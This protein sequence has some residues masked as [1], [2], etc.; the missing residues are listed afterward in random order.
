MRNRKDQRVTI[1]NG[2]LNKISVQ[3]G[4]TGYRKEMVNIMSEIQTQIETEPKPGIPVEAVEKKEEDTAYTKRL[5]E[6]FGFFGPVTF[7]YACI[8]AFCTFQNDAGMAFPFFIAASLLFFCFSLSKLE[9]TLKSGS[10][11]YMVSM[12]LLAVSTFCTDDRRIIIMNKTG[13][14]LLTMS[15]LLK[16]FCD[17][18]KWKLQKYFNSIIVLTFAS[19]ANLVRPVTDGKAF[20]EDKKKAGKV[21]YIFLGLLI[22]VPLLAVVLSLLSS[23]DA[24][25]RNV[26]GDFLKNINFANI[27]NVIWRVTFIFFASYMLLSYLCEGKISDQV[28][29]KRTGE[30][31][32]AITITG[33][34]TLI[35][36]F[37]SVIQIVYLFL[38]RM[39]LPEAYTYAQYARE[40]FFQLLAVSF[41][42]LIIVLV[43]MGRFRESRI[44][45]GV[46]IVMSLC[47]FIM[48]AS[49]A[50]RMI[51]YIRYYYM[52]FLRLFVLWA[53]VLLFAMFVGIVIQILK[54]EFPLFRYGVI[55]VTV[56]YMA[57]S[58]SHPD[59][60][61]AKINVANIEN[62]PDGSREVSEDDFFQSSYSYRDF[63]YL[64]GLSADAAPVLL[65]YMDKEGYDFYIDDE[66]EIRVRESEGD[67]SPYSKTGLEH[68]YL[69]HIKIVTESLNIRT[70]NISRYMALKQIEKYIEQ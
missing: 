67:P 33:L 1:L 49:S 19:L 6:H 63:D 68:G 62:N 70:F 41:L 45:K 15:L 38:G 23:A 56:L 31:L 47:S 46:L 50:M 30:P 48:I 39:Q 2:Y 32:I 51:I 17:T 16:Q 69:T 29:D 11:F 9:I 21:W 43:C 10:A 18:S 60:I 57:L 55:V 40:G 13:I 66:G 28:K 26:L 12:M 34:L 3:A 5:K 65:A 25:F 8:Y 59:Y 54:E 36:V 20:Y 64:E 44:L 7:V 53:L 42:N 58:F 52:T 14:F 35:Y 4:K 61:I 37:F 27:I 22:A 24:V